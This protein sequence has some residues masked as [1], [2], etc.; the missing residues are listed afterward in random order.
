MNEPSYEH[1]NHEAQI[2]QQEKANGVGKPPFAC[3]DGWH[4]HLHILE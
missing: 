2:G 1:E 3:G 4:F